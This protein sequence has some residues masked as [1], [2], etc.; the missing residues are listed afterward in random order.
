MLETLFDL[1]GEWALNRA[2]RPV[3]IG[4]TVLLIVGAAGLLALVLW[5]R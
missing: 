3:R 4:C 2:P 1:I 5:P